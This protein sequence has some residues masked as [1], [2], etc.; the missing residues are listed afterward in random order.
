MEE[1]AVLGI[2]M[3]AEYSVDI[4]ELE[5]ITFNWSLFFAPILYPSI[6]ES[7]LTL[8]FVYPYKNNL[9]VSPTDTVLSTSIE[10]YSTLVS[11]SSSSFGGMIWVI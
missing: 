5:I 6:T 4:P 1:Y 3:R 9:L 7:G 10:T 2:I 8:W 11:I